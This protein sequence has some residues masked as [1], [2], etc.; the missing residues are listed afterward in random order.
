VLA[1]TLPAALLWLLWPAAGVPPPAGLR[2]TFLD[3]GQ[4]DAIL[5]QVPEGAILV[6]QGPP[7]A[8]VA[9]QLREL[10]VRHLSAL[11]LTDG[12]RD[13]TG[14]AEEIVRRIGIERVLDPHI[15]SRSSYRERALAAAAERRIPIAEVRAGATWTLGGLR[16]RALWPDGPGSP[17]DDP[18]SRTVVLLARYGQVDALLSADAETD[19]TAPLLSQRVEI[20]KV[21][22]HGSQDPGL[23]A[24]LRQLAPALAVIS[25]GRGNDYGHPRRE[26][27]AALATVPGLETFRTDVDGRIVVESDGSRI[28]VRTRR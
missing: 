7:E 8:R 25:C 17:G 27:L 23:E 6:D 26:T 4:G 22:H 18:N 9:R 11:V 14:G 13:H 24:E 10:G 16:L 20:L 12:Q 19:V 28:W 15:A 3:V 2:I 5:V 1:A 21:A